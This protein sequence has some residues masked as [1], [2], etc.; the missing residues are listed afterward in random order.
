MLAATLS[1]KRVVVVVVALAADVTGVN[2]S[3]DHIAR[4]GGTEPEMPSQAGR[5]ERLPVRCPAKR[6]LSVLVRCL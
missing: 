5:R 4:A 1:T 6:H 2:E 3:V